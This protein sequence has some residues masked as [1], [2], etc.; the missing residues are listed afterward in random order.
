MRNPD[1]AGAESLK[2]R[3]TVETDLGIKELLTLSLAL[4]RSSPAMDA[5]VRAA[6][7]LTALGWSVTNRRFV[8]S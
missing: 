2:A 5:A 8:A 3:L 4:G 1:P 6:K 7:P